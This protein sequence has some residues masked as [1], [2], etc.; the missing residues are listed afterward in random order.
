MNRTDRV[1]EEIQRE[2]I[3]RARETY[4]DTVVDH[5]LNPRNPGAMES[6]DGYAKIKGPCGDTMEIF[7]RIEQGRIPDASFLTDGCITSLVAG[8][9]AVELAIGREVPDARAI[10]RDDIL[11]ALGGLPEESE[12]CALL[13]SDTLRAAIDDGLFK[14]GRG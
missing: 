6:P 1:V 14:E 10:S 5:W 11:R 13:A 9:M 4:S 3:E 2:I 12:H 8:S 7:V